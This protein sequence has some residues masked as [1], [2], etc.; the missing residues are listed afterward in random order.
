MLLKTA[1]ENNN[2]DGESAEDK[3]ERLGS[4]PTDIT[5]VE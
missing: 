2:V 1:W 4:K 5:L 3:I